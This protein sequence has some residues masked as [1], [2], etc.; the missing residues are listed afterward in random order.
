MSSLPTT[1][2][3]YNS[4]AIVE[5]IKMLKLERE[6]YEAKAAA[7]EQR[8]S[9]C[10]TNTTSALTVAYKTCI[11]IVMHPDFSGVWDKLMSIAHSAISESVQ[12]NT[13]APEEKKMV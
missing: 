4:D 12:N 2:P 11:R 13:V 10:R 3:T 8:K 1:T 5:H 6:Y 9:Y 7:D